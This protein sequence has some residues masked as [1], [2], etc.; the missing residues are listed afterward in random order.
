MQWNCVHSQWCLLNNA[1]DYYRG[2]GTLTNENRGGNRIS[3]YKNDVYCNG[4]KYQCVLRLES[5]YFRGKGMF[6]ITSNKSL[7]WIDSRKEP[8]VIDM[9]KEVPF[10]FPRMW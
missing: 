10:F 8:K 3:E 5:E 7:I 4:K 6:A 1:V 2:T 9:N